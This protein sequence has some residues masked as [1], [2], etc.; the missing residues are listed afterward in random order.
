MLTVAHA[1]AGWGLLAHGDAPLRP[2]DVP[3]AW[4]LDPVLLALLAVAAVAYARGWRSASDPPTRRAAFWIGM[5]VVGLAVVS[6]LDPLSETLLSAHMVQHVLL[7]VVAAPL[8]AWSAPGAAL[9]RGL[10]DAPRRWIRVAR[11]AGRVDARTI[12]RSRAPIARWLAYVA[13][14]WGWHASALYGAAIEHRLVHAV[15]HAT[16]LTVGWAVWSSIVG[17]ERVRVD[18][19]LALLGVFTLGLQSVFLA[20]LLTFST[21]PWY[22]AYLGPTT[23]FGLDPL[24][25]QQLAGVLMWVPA[26]LVHAGIGVTILVRWLADLDDPAATLRAV[27]TGG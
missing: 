23:A 17:P 15:E 4:N 26:G 21:S 7:L 16:F 12:R 11:R 14:L 5:A 6:P 13:V 8:L 3:G 19:G 10:P 24:T 18:R 27:R 20:V 1:E 22:E 9:Q 25:D 2:H